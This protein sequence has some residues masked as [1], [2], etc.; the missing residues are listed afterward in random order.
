MSECAN[1][2]KSVYVPDGYEFEDGDLC[3]SC[4][5]KLIDDLRR[6]IEQW[7]TWG[8]IEIAV[9]NPNVMEY[10]RHWEGRALKA[11][12]KVSI[13]EIP[14]FET[15]GICEM[16]NKQYT[17]KRAKQ[18]YCSSKCRTVAGMR[19]YRNKKKESANGTESEPSV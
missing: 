11:E 19:R 7:K 13:L 4:K 5:D 16:C 8:I 1:C 3:F 14:K 17:R 18:N 2:N 15:L 6:E 10:M 12:A 9:R